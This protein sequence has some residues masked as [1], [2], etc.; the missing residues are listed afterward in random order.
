MDK[1]IFQFQSFMLNRW[2]VI[3]HDLYRSGIK[4]GRTSQALNIAT[5][6]ALA[7]FAEL[8]IRKASN[9]LL[10]V[11]FSA[12]K[13]EPVD[14]EPE[15]Q[16]EQNLTTEFLLTVLFNIPFVSSIG[17]FFGYGSVPVPALSAI[18]RVGQASADA[19]RSKETSTRIKNF[20]RAI[21]LG[22]GV[23]FGL[24]GAFQTEQIIRKTGAAGSSAGAP[25]G[26]I[27]R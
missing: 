19:I 15:S 25:T 22:L 26:G 20:A 9:E 10:S 24:P 21:A 1:A 14:F 18:Q 23:G 27:K 3:R 8:G 17:G 6:L 5:W 4:E 16:K 11:I 7:S 12:L 2:S 13:G